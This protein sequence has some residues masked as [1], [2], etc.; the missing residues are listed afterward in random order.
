[1]HF[2]PQ[3]TGCNPVCGGRRCDV[4]GVALERWPTTGDTGENFVFL[5]GQQEAA[6]L[7]PRSMRQG[8]GWLPERRDVAGS[9]QVGRARTKDDPLEAV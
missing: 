6:A 4:T 9:H 5:G 8:A 7:V 3:A 2:D 1:M